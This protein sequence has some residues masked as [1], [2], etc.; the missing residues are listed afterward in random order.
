[1]A[2]LGASFKAR[3]AA[4]KFL[5]P[6]QLGQ[7]ATAR[8]IMVRYE[9][10]TILLMDPCRGFRKPLPGPGLISSPDW[11]RIYHVAVQWTNI[12]YLLN[13]VNDFMMAILKMG[14]LKTF[15]IVTT[16]VRYGVQGRTDC[17]VDL[18]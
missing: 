18:K 6:L 8:P 15:T 4:F 1:M 3:Q 10:N 12:R 11:R 2:A 9:L 13:N 7:P 17:L 14:N 16:Y 5:E